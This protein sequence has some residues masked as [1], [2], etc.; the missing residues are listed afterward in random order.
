MVIGVVAGQEQVK[1]GEAKKEF[2]LGTVCWRKLFG[3]KKDG[4]Q[5]WRGPRWVSSTPKDIT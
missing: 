2:G 1:C 4:T 5:T 3:G